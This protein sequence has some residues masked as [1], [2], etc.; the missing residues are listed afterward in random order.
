MSKR[1]IGILI[2]LAVVAFYTLG[3]GFPFFFRFLYVISLVLVFGLFWAWVN[4][5]GLEVR[6]NRLS[7]RG[8]VGG[9]LEGQVQVANRFRFPKSWLEVRELSD[10]PGYTTGRGIAMVRDQARSWRIQTYLARR[11]VFET[12][13]VEVTSQDPFGLFRLSRRFLEP[14]PYVVFPASEPLPDL[15]PSSPLCPAT[16]GS[17][18]VRTTLLPSPPVSG[19]TFTATATG[20]SIGPTPPG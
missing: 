6:L 11:G 16:A 19:S 20:R 14:Q 10:I 2:L 5:R 9:Y 4:L 18:G 8:Q 12:G 17:P 13:R 7:H 15:D 1:T 3:T